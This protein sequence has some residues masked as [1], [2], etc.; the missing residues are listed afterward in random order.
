MRARSASELYRKAT[1]TRAGGSN[2][3]LANG[4][5][6]KAAAEKLAKKCICRRIE[7]L[8]RKKGE[9]RERKRRG[10]IFLCKKV[11][12]RKSLRQRRMHKNDAI[13]VDVVADAD[14]AGAGRQICKM[15]RNAEIG[16]EERQTKKRKERQNF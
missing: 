10:G 7:R 8:W 16:P 1:H 11:R 6:S 5:G 12:L 3:G 14:A 2:P 15:E 13:V 4:L 9:R